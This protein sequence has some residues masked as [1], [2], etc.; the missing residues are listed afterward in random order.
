MLGQTVEQAVQQV[1]D[2]RVM[3]QMVGQQA[4]GL[5]GGAPALLAALAAVA[6]LAAEEVQHPIQRDGGAGAVPVDQVEVGVDPG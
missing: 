1:P 4:D 3:H 5:G 6:E 2:R